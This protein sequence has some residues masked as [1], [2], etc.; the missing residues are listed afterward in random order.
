MSGADSS[1]VTRRGLFRRGATAAAGT[2]AIVGGGSRIA[3]RYSPIG[4]AAAVA[5]VAVIGIAAGGAAVG[6]LAGEAADRYLGDSRDY[7]GYT[8][9]DALHQE[10]TVGANEMLSAN[11]RVMTSIENNVANSETVALAKGKAAIIETMNAGGTESEA[12]SAMQNAIDDYYATIQK[13]II[14]HWNAQYRQ[15]VHHVEQWIAHEETSSPFPEWEFY[16]EEYMQEWVDL[17]LDSS[18]N[19]TSDAEA[20]FRYD[21]SIDGTKHENVAL[22][23]GESAAADQMFVSYS[24]MFMGIEDPST[25]DATHGYFEFRFIDPDGNQITY[26]DPSRFNTVWNELIT[27]R[28]RV[29][30]DLSGF[31]EDVYANYDPGDIPTEDLVD[32]ITAATELRQNYDNAS[33]QSA[34]AAMLG[35]PT[36]ANL[37]ADLEIQSSEAEDGVWEVSADI[38]T[39]HV[40]RKD[41]TSSASISSGT[42]SLSFEPVTDATY[43]ATT[44]AD[45]TVDVAAADWTDDGDGTWS[46]D[47]SGDLS[48]TDTSLETMLGQEVGF[49]TGNS[50]DP[51]TWSDP[52]YIAYNYIDELSGEKKGAFTQIESEFTIVEVTDSN[53]DS[54]DSFEPES[55]N[56]QTADVTK[57]EEELAQ[58]REE[59]IRLQEEAQENT[60]GS[61]GGD[62][63]TD[64]QTLIL[65]GFAALIVSTIAALAMQDDQ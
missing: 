38:F 51:S 6:Y 44:A 7:S 57:L 21:E 17:E 9:V 43:T 22:L 30:S 18:T 8:G 42:L 29:N 33:G 12:T 45:E 5:P 19:A 28:D 14:S 52:L 59:Q 4:R 20:I 65:G 39:A 36:T 56:N 50:Y 2:A 3:P 55:R 31:V 13:N 34:H 62:S 15:L 35:I 27:A 10:I 61:S 26:L 58:L 40:P 11:E 60:G 54:V 37:S 25:Y 53:G 16:D 49:K 46:Y 23:N 24:S 64:N 1:G 63:G 48:T 47:A 32:P 41:V